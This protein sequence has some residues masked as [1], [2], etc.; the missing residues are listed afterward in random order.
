MLV[1]GGQVV[2]YKKK[3]KKT[4]WGNML[5][6][7]SKNTLLRKAYDAIAKCKWQIISDPIDWNV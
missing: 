7:M 2:I 3:Q 4:I 6:R 5:L 1:K